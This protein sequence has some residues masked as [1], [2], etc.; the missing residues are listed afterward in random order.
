MLVEDDL[1]TVQTEKKKEIIEPGIPSGGKGETEVTEGN[2]QA[3][4]LPQILFAGLFKGGDNHCANQT[5]STKANPY[6][7]ASSNVMH[8]CSERYPCVTSSSQF[9]KIGS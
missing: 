1:P 3:R 6:L 5:K 8:C 4:I 9:E 7:G 2:V